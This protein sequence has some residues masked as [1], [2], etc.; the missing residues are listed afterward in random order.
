[1]EKPEAAADTPVPA[2]DPAKVKKQ[3]EFYFSDS[4]FPR[5]KFLRTEASKDPDGCIIITLCPSCLPFS[6]FRLILH[7]GE[8]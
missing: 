2:P 3:V 4:N 6:I 5:D 8:Y 7:R 1:M